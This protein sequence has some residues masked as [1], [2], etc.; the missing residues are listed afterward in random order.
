M[1]LRINPENTWKTFHLILSSD[2]NTYIYLKTNKQKNMSIPRSWL[3]RH[4]IIKMAIYKFIVIP[5]NTPLVFFL[6]LY[7]KSHIEKSMERTS[8]DY[9]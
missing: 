7:L 4:R 5:I 1:Y 9:V 2:I 3:G 6:E 8:Q